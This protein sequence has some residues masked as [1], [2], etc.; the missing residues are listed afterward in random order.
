VLLPGAAFLRGIASVPKKTLRTSHCSSGGGGDKGGEHKSQPDKSGGRV[1]GTTRRKK[2][3]DLVG[4]RERDWQTHV[5]TIFGP[6]MCYYWR[7]KEAEVGARAREK[8][9]VFGQTIGNV[10]PCGSQ[11][12]RSHTR[13][14]ST[15]R[16]DNMPKNSR[17]QKHLGEGCISNSK[18]HATSPRIEGSHFACRVSKEALQAVAP[19]RHRLEAAV[20]R[21]L[22]LSFS[23]LVPVAGVGQVK[24]CACRV[25]VSC[26]MASCP[27]HGIVAWTI[28]TS[29]A[30]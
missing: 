10:V 9:H 12:K 11:T 25:P 17:G 21:E 1:C 5:A 24:S 30:S 26:L 16:R 13:S 15:T 18:S 19:L 22:V 3:K 23:S 28:R 8:Q 6:P 29:L 2:Q 27:G 7:S 14:C 4:L 20:S